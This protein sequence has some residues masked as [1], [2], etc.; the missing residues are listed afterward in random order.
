MQAYFETIPSTSAMRV[1]KVWKVAAL[2]GVALLIAAA[3]SIGA[4]LAVRHAGASVYADPPTYSAVG[5]AQSSVPVD[6]V[7]P[8][9]PVPAPYA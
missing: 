2:S 7:L 3:V 9:C 4:V 1:R 6:L 5:D 8:C